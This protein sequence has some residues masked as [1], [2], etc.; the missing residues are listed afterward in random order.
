MGRPAKSAAAMAYGSGVNVQTEVPRD[1]HES[2]RL[3]V[4]RRQG[5]GEHATARSVI[6][7]VI[8]VASKRWPRISL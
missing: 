8:L 7:E 2:L 6:L 4:M 3:E 5:A 1:I